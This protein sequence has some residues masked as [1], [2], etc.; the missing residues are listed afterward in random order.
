MPKVSQVAKCSDI[1]PEIEGESISD[2]RV[3]Y[4]RCLRQAGRMKYSK[5]LKTERVTL[6]QTQIS[7]AI[8]SLVSQIET[9]SQRIDQLERRQPKA[10]STKG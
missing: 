8:R 1:F 7:A 6:T 9:L 2:R 5:A 10:K 3:R 4:W